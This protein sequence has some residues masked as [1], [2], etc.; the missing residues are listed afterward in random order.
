MFM[1][2]FTNHNFHPLNLKK[3]TQ[4]EMRTFI[5]V[6]NTR[7]ADT[8]TPGMRCQKMKTKSAQVVSKGGDE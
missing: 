5:S 4:H 3:T 2:L 8:T 6:M 1:L 7:G